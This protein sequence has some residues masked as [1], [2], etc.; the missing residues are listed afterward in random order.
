M[1]EIVL[2]KINLTPMDET[3]WATYVAHVVDAEEFYIQYGIEPCKGSKREKD[4]RLLRIRRK[5]RL[6]QRQNTGHNSF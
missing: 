2:E 4:M 3:D 5:R 6:L 1:N